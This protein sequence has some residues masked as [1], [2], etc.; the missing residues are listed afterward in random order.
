MPKLLFPHT[1]SSQ[2]TYPKVSIVIQ[3][4]IAS[5]NFQLLF[6]LCSCCFLCLFLPPLYFPLCFDTI[7]LLKQR[8]LVILHEHVQVAS[9]RACSK[10]NSLHVGY[11][12]PTSHSHCC[13]KDTW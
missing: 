6:A 11:K 5:G 9:H 12:L 4:W 2:A 1:Y 3:Q 8:P 7:E 13:I 10:V